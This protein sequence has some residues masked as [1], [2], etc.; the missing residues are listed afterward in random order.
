M[1]D[2]K[3]SEEPVSP[4]KKLHQDTFYLGQEAEA[5]EAALEFLKSLADRATKLSIETLE[6]ADKLAADG[7]PHKKLIAGTIKDRVV[8][9]FNEIASGRP[10][11]GAEGGDAQRATPFSNSSPRSETTSERLSGP[12]P[13]PEPKTLSQPAPTPRKRGRPPK[14]RPE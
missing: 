1:A 5:R 2:E 11:Q 4:L 9:A 12:S 7:D 10:S 6:M 13:A 8:M 3:P 14:K